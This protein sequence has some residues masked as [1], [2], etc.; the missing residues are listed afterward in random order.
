MA[1]IFASLHTPR[2]HLLNFN[3]RDFVVHAAAYLLR[4]GIEVDEDALVAVVDSAVDRN[5]DQVLTPLHHISTVCFGGTDPALP[6]SSS[7]AAAHPLALIAHTFLPDSVS[8]TLRQNKTAIAS[9]H[10]AACTVIKTIAQER[11]D[12]YH[13]LR[14]LREGNPPVRG[15]VAC[16]YLP[17]LKDELSTFTHVFDSRRS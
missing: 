7:P 17:G 11:K 16:E 1:L 8:E 13:L 15:N 6:S 4:T 9:A 12:K 3:C 10:H 14:R 5:E 2:Y